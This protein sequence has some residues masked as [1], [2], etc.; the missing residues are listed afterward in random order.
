M[1]RYL[2][3][4]SE[5]DTELLREEA[6]NNTSEFDILEQ[7]HYADRDGWSL[8]QYEGYC[9]CVVLNGRV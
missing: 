6:V 8:V 9:I 2:F 5:C 1:Y 7:E 3:A 4:N